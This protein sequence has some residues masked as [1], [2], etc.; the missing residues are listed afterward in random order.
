MTRYQGVFLL[1]L[2]VLAVWKLSRVARGLHARAASPWLTLLPWLAPPL[3]LLRGGLSPLRTHLAQI[4]ERSSTDPFVTLIQTYWYMFEQFLLM[5]PYFVTY[6]IFG[7]L[8]YGLFRTQWSTARLRWS[9]PARNRSARLLHR[10]GAGP[11]VRSLA[12]SGDI[13][14]PRRGQTSAMVTRRAKPRRG[15]SVLIFTGLWR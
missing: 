15:A 8:L 12:I 10:R 3:W 14:P 7:F 11:M 9:P 5:S 4:A 13:L 2:A 6:G 1:P